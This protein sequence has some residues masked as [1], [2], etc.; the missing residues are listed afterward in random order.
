MRCGGR[1]CENEVSAPGLCHRCTTGG[2]EHEPRILSRQRAK[3][4][5][6]EFSLIDLCRLLLAKAVGPEGLSASNGAR[7]DVESDGCKLS[8]VR[9]KPKRKA[10]SG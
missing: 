5:C 6:A 7:M 1:D 4:L 8:L 10:R 2:V 9:R 3:E